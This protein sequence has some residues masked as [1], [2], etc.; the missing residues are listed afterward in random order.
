MRKLI[1]IL[2]VILFSC[3]SV[4]IITPKFK[5]YDFVCLKSTLE[6]G[7]IMYVEENIYTIQVQQ[8]GLDN[9]FTYYVKH[10]KEDELEYCNKVKG[11]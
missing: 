11:N 3:T 10:F 9:N 1:I 2:I 4:N 8:K 5:M 6:P 7:Y